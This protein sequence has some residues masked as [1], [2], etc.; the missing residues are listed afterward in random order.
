[1]IGISAETHIR[2]CAEDELRLARHRQEDSGR[3]RE[4]VRALVMVGLLDRDLADRILTG[5][6]R[7]LALRGFP[8]YG[9][10]MGSAPTPAAER[11]RV[12]GCTGEVDVSGATVIPRFVVLGAQRTRLA[13]TLRLTA[14][15]GSPRH[16]GHPGFGGPPSL[17]L[18]D[19]AG[20]SVTAHFSGGGGGGT[21][22]RGWYTA[23]P[24]LSPN[25]AWI[26]I[27]R[28]RLPLHDPDAGADVIVE[29]LLDPDASVEQRAARYLTHCID[30]T[31]G[32]HE[33]GS[34]TVA[35]ETLV[36]CGVLAPDASIVQQ[37]LHDEGDG[38]MPH[39]M[40]RRHRAQ[41]R[42]AQHSHRAPGRERSVLVGVA[43]PPFDG[44][45][46]AVTQLSC[47]PYGF[48]VEIDGYGRIGA[49]HEPDPIDAPRLAFAAADDLGNTYLGMIGEFSHGGEEFSGTIEFDPELDARA[50]R[51]DV[52]VSTEA[53]RATVRV[54]VQQG[55]RT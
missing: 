8:S 44:I 14:Q 6:A 10:R 54:P 20:H 28:T 43:T 17:T 22:W 34:A 26:A 50:S 19:D 32:S 21:D 53:A 29:S 36:A 7:A 39:P 1:V 4:G 46:V 24:G 47:R 2:R 16:P 45:A 37:A 18:R 13:V 3:L 40:A 41:L 15:G 12:C 52:I 35:A 30:V 27:E 55:M 11:Q 42:A 5:Y 25:T 38:S 9:L 23:E 49:H 51:V 33:P 48:S 31:H